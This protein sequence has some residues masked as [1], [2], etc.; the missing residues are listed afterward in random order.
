MRV[1]DVSVNEQPKFLTQQLTNQSHALVLNQDE[2]EE[3]T[4]IPLLLKGVTSY[5]SARKPSQQEYDA[6]VDLGTRFDMTYAAPQ[7]DPQATMFQEQA[8]Q[9]L[10][11][12]GMLRDFDPDVHCLQASWS[13]RPACLWGTL[14]C[15]VL[16]CV[17]YKSTG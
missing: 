11:Y 5:F 1:N 15:Q 2:D 10:D 9:Y 12:N 7:W 16:S 8:D 3:E 17:P 14:Y 13:P 6:S 4:I